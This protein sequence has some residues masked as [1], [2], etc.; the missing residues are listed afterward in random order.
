MGE[1][2]RAAID[3]ETRIAIG[4]LLSFAG[5][6]GVRSCTVRDITNVGA[7]IRIQELPA[8]SLNFELSFDNFQPEVSADLARR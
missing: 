7:G 3:R 5:Q 8:V 1:R 4:A 6:A 2:V